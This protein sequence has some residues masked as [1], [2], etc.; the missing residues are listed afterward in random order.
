VVVGLKKAGHSCHASTNGRLAGVQSPAA[1]TRFERLKRQNAELRRANHDLVE[2][3]NLAIAKIQRLTLDNHHLRH[4][5]EANINVT[6]IDA[7]HRPDTNC[8]STVT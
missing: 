7:R 1:V 8:P 5:L 2:H 3:L 6:S 4:Q